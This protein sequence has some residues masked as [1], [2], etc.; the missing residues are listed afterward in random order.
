MVTS[1]TSTLSLLATDNSKAVAR[2]QFEDSRR[3]ARSRGYGYRQ[4]SGDGSAAQPRKAS[5]SAHAQPARLCLRPLSLEL[6][7]TFRDINVAAENRSKAFRLN[8]EN[9]SKAFRLNGVAQSHQFAP[10]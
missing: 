5:L 1:A 9:R 4:A 6:V 8:A 2:R 3:L 7:G 10:I